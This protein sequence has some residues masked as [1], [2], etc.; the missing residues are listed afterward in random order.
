MAMVA[1]CWSCQDEEPLTP[2]FKEEET[3]AVNPS[4]SFYPTQGAE[5]TSMVISGLEFSITVNYNKVSFP[6][7]GGGFKTVEADY[8]SR[9]QDSIWV[10]VPP[11]VVSG[12]I[13][14]SIEEQK[15]LSP[16]P[17]TV[18]EPETGLRFSP[19][20]ANPEKM[21]ALYGIPFSENL[22]ENAV[23]CMVGGS[24]AGRHRTQVFRVDAENQVLWIR[25]SSLAES[26]KVVATVKGKTY[27][28]A[29]ELPVV[30][31]SQEEISGADAKF[32]GITAMT[33]GPDG[34]VYVLDNGEGN[35]R[36][37]KFNPETMEVTTLAGGPEG[38]AD[39]MGTA[40]MFK[41]PLDLTFGPDKQLYVTDQ[42]N[43]RIRRV[44][45][46]TGEV[47]TVAG[48]DTRGAQDGIGS[49]VSFNL[50]QGITAA[51]DGYLYISEYENNLIRRLDPVS[52]EVLTIA[53]NGQTELMDGPAAS[54]G[55]GRPFSMAADGDSVL[56]IVDE[57][58]EVI[59]KLDLKKGVVSSLV[60]GK[61]LIT[62][63]GEEHDYA[64]NP[65]DLMMDSENR[66]LYYT[67]G[68]YMDEGS[69]NSIDLRTGI[70]TTVAGGKY[71]SYVENSCVSAGYSYLG[72]VLSLPDGSFLMSELREGM[73]SRSFHMHRIW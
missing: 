31:C 66:I 18:I 25:L 12:P 44:D 9:N 27:T 5:G 45:P 49:A 30:A 22:K 51:G 46:M 54:A 19:G 41:Q 10:I 28:S 13:S 6:V 50:P 69:L 35:S 15:S 7:E 64:D 71:H 36:I 11:G 38:F 59:R 73:N 21:V 16:A 39:G 53:G 17:F 29:L 48:S 14:I 43:H 37:R 56:Y 68:F 42:W 4:I 2:G 40:A 34:M 1:M 60:E 33:L 61:E 32:S 67:E 70:V 58:E 62:I 47:S 8:Y 23:S 20:T 57:V 3:G 55:F 26:G 52:G 24:S 63:S 65:V 72:D